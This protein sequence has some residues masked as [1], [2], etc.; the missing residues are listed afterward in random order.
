MSYVF[1]VTPPVFVEPMKNVTVIDGKDSQIPCNVIG[2]PTPNTTW[3]HNGRTF[4]VIPY[5]GLF[6]QFNWEL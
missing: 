5:F 3:S 6:N 2:A 1:A 4:N